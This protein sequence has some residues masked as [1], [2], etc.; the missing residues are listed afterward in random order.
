MPPPANLIS[1]GVELP[2]GPAEP[3]EV[4]GAAAPAIDLELVDIR[5]VDV[6]NIQANVGPR[7]RLFCRNN[8][9]LEAP[10]FQ[11]NVMADLGK[12]LTP[13][14][15]LVTVECVGIKPG[16]TQAIDIQLPVGVLK[17]TTANDKWPKP[18]ELLV[19]V[20]NSDDSLLESNKDNNALARTRDAIKPLTADDAASTR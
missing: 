7:F 20:A 14:A 3:V 2:L 17:M 9:K 12:K 13:T 4:M 15:H 16:K 19:A 18:F 5:L 6:G 10:K 11:I 8:G 1:W